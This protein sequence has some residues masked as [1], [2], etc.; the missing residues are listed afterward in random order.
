[1]EPLSEFDAI[2]RRGEPLAPYTHLRLGGPA[3]MLVQP[4]ALDEL[5]GVV[6]RCFEQGIPLRVLGSGCNMLV[7]DEGV[8]GAV[9]RLSEPAFTQISVEGER[10]RAGTGAS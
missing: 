7:R 1:M 3:A 4:R 10:V 2:I 5:S 8:G 9:L 6:R